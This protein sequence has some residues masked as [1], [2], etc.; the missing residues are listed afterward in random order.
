M[1]R[2]RSF[3]FGHFFTNERFLIRGKYWEELA[4]EE[5]SALFVSKFV[6]KWNAGRLEQ[7]YYEGI[8]EQVIETTKRTRHTWGFVKKLDEK[9]KFELATAK[10]SVHVATKRSSTFKH[11]N[12]A[13]HAHK[14]ASSSGSSDLNP[15]KSLRREEEDEEDRRK[16]KKTDRN[17][18]RRDKNAVLEELVP[19]ETGKEAMIEKRRQMSQKLH[20][21]AKEREDAKDGL[22]LG[23]DFLMGGG[24]DELQSR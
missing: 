11:E 17:A 24:S 3:C 19:K 21:A 2:I 1:S 10:D 18:Y 9:E 23:E 6:K 20:G 15:R 5:A 8:P 14:T 22:D 16:R 12:S 13:G 7:M 4:T